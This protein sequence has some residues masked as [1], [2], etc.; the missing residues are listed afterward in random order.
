MTH[1]GK[2]LASMAA[3]LTLTLVSANPVWAGGPRGKNLKTKNAKTALREAGTHVARSVRN[4]AHYYVGAPVAR[5]G[6]LSATRFNNMGKPT[7]TVMGG[8]RKVKVN[9]LAKVKKPTG[10]KLGFKDVITAKGQPVWLAPGRGNAAKMF[11]KYE[12]MH[13]LG[14]PMPIGISKDGKSVL[15][16]PQQLQKPNFPRNRFSASQIEGLIG[17][18]EALVRQGVELKNIVVF[19]SNTNIPTV[20]FNHKIASLK[21]TVKQ[22]GPLKAVTRVQKQVE[23]QIGDSLV[24]AKAQELKAQTVAVKQQIAREATAVN[25]NAG[26]RAVAARTKLDAK[27]R[28]LVELAGREKELVAAIPL[29]AT[30]ERLTSVVLESDPQVEKLQRLGD[31]LQSVIDAK[32]A[33]ASEVSALEAELVEIPQA[34]ERQLKNLERKKANI[35]R[36]LE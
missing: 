14:G 31:K 1:Q 4:G 21:P 34:R 9:T 23:R 20:R 28:V 33:T 27:R 15:V 19:V 3:V 8:I 7:R 24:Y 2:T 5:L 36:K 18:T 13:A 12:Q 6:K 29:Q 30:T 32:N 10:E 22:N 26:T 25:R 17:Q 35:I 16:E 11:A